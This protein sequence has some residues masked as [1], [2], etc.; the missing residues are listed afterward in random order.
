MKKRIVQLDHRVKVRIRRLRRETRAANVAA[1]CQIILLAAKRRSSRAIAEAVGCHRSWVS[2]V[3]NAFLTL[4]ESA[5]QDGREDN[6]QEK[7]DEYFLATLYDV[8][9]GSPQDHGLRPT[10]WT[11]E[12]L[13][14]VLAMLTGIRVHPGTMSRALRQIRARHGRPRP[15][16]ECPWSKAWKTR[17]LNQL[18]RLADQSSEREPV[19]YEDEVDI[20][21]NPKIGPDWMN[22]GQ[23]KEVMTPGQNEKQYIAGAMHAQTRRVTHV[24]GSRKNSLLFVTLLEQLLDE[25]PDATRIHVILDNYRIHSSKIVQG[26]LAGFEGRVVL[27]FLPPYCPD[28]NKIERLWRDLHAD[29]TRNHCCPDMDTLMANVAWFLDDHNVKAKQNADREAE[30]GQS[31]AKLRKVI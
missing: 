14:L 10:T 1:R 19:F 7:V 15:R 2:R 22:R 26:A 18:R 21:L 13:A 31:G 29:V 11:Q 25:Y 9:G 4:G 28:Y 24:Q 23:Q 20:H 5:L 12:R 30:S 8:V 27:H 16:V 17:R 6:G 3:I